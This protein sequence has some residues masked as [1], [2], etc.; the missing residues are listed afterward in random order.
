LAE[1]VVQEMRRGAAIDRTSY[2]PIDEI[3]ELTRTRTS[4]LL[5]NV[6]DFVVRDIAT[7]RRSSRV[8]DVADPIAIRF[9]VGWLRSDRVTSSAARTSLCRR[10]V[11]MSES[12]ADGA[13]WKGCDDPLQVRVGR[14]QERSVRLEGEGQVGP[15]FS[16]FT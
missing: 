13:L 11:G 5:N 3:A 15:E 8:R 10:G 9:G 4:R 12:R 14:C 1:G 2:F 6:A 16:E 7:R